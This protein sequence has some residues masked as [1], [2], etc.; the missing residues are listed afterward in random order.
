LNQSKSRLPWSAPQSNV[1]CID[2]DSLCLHVREQIVD[3]KGQ[4]SSVT[5]EAKFDGN[6]YPVIGSPFVDAV[7]YRRRD[8]H[9]ISGY[10][11]KAAKLL[12]KETVAISPDGRTMTSNYYAA[13]QE[14]AALGFA[15]F[16]KQ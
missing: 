15:V 13:S 12:L 2:A 8:Q 14:D 4:E 16:D 1:T 6:D 10:I 5:L 7:S 3:D 11:K 9:T